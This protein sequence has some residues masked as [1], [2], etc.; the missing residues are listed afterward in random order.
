[1]WFFLKKFWRFNMLLIFMVKHY[2]NMMCKNS[3][4]AIIIIGVNAQYI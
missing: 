2:Y 1:M 3:L 4:C